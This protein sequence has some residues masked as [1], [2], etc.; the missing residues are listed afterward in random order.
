[1]AP[2]CMQKSHSSGSGMFELGTGLAADAAPREERQAVEPMALCE[3]A[4][5]QCPVHLTPYTFEDGPN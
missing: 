3:T 4:Q 2:N 5:R 1:M